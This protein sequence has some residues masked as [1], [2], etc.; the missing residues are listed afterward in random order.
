MCLSNGAG[1]LSAGRG[2]AARRSDHAS[3]SK[4]LKLTG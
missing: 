4:T 2:A 3:A 1:L